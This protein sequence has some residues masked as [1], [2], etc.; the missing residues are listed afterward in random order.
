MLSER[1]GK[2]IGFWR[3]ALLALKPFL[4]PSTRNSVANSWLFTGLSYA[5]RAEALAQAAREMDEQI[6]S[7]PTTSNP[8]RFPQPSD[9]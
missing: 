2:T 9:N 4:S 5:D 1:A 7:T 3:R 6:I 8:P